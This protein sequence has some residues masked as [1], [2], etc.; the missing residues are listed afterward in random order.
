MEMRHT[1]IIVTSAPYLNINER[2]NDAIFNFNC[3][4]YES[5]QKIKKDIFYVDINAIITSKD[6][7]R[8]GIHLTKL[9]KRTLFKYLCRHV[10]DFKPNLN[11]HI[12]FKNL[13]QLSRNDD[14]SVD[15]RVVKLSIVNE[16]D[17]DVSEDTSV[18]ISKDL[19]VDVSNDVSSDMI[20]TNLS[21]FTET[22]RLPNFHACPKI[23]V[24]P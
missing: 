10:V 18:D 8:N 20:N 14:L 13:I 23:L 19:S 21:Q 7:Q 1:N 9:G 22:P 24:K 15:D 17:C 11:I 3:Q 6:I 4:L 2:L 5:I 16:E 12:N